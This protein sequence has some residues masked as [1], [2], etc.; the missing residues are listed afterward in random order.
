VVG[1]IVNYLEA[2][3]AQ[4]PGLMLTVIVPE[5]KVRHHWHRLLHDRLGD[6]LRRALEHHEG[7]VVAEVPFPLSS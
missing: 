7:I 5:I 1:P 2:L 3:H 6:R 4:R